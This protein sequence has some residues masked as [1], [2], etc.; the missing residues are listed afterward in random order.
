M[1]RIFSLLIALSVSQLLFAQDSTSSPQRIK[2]NISERGSDHLLIQYGYTG[3]NGT[4]DSIHTKGFSRHFN[5]YF[6]F[7]KPFKTNPRFSAAYGVG[8]GSDNMFF[9]NTYVD[10]KSTGNSLPFTRTDSTSHFKKY[11]LTTIYLEAPVELRFNANP[12]DP[13]SGFKFAIGAKVGTMLKAF[14]KGKDLQNKNGQTVYGNKYIVKEAEKHFFNS[15]RL[16]ATARIGYGHWTLH[17][18]Y[19]VTQ[20]LKENA[21]PEIRPFQIGLT[22]SGL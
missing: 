7:D 19:Q 12:N 20:L 18:A 10:V 17:G 3:W 22:V 16:S 8:I 2:V 1:K 6:M 14:T 5:I 13:A 11:K 15:T 4:P 9:R 21:G